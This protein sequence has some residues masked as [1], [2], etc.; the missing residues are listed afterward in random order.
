MVTPQQRLWGIENLIKYFFLYHNGQ[1][2]AIY[3]PSGNTSSKFIEV[4]YL[5][6]MNY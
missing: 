6:S 3:P 5:G 4:N 1:I 2:I